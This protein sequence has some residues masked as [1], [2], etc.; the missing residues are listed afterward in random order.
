MLHT[1]VGSEHLLIGILRVESCLA[2]RILKQQGVE[3]SSLREQVL[4]V[5][6]LF[7]EAISRINKGESITALFD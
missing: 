5:A 4:S 2:A 1:A 7:G 6:H 3:L